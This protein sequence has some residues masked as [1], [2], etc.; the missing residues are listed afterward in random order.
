MIKNIQLYGERCSGTNY[1]QSLIEM[2]F[3]EIPV[4]WQ[5]GWKHWFP[6]LKNTKETLF[7]VIIRDPLDWLSS[8]NRTPFHTELKKLSFSEFIRREWYSVY[9]SDSGFKEDH[10]LIGKE[11]IIDRDPE[12]GK[13]FEN[14]I[15]LRNSK[16]KH[17][18]GIENKVEN[19][20]FVRYEDISGD[21]SIIKDVA[22]KFNISL[23]FPE[24]RRTEY[25]KGNKTF[26]VYKKKEY[27]K[28]SE[29]DRQFILSQL[30]IEQENK[31]GYLK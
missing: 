10:P 17:F 9:D 30:D 26:G 11:M 27:Q 25:F 22:A 2:N 5:H 8:I 20:A 1:L 24:I 6:K 15:K 7:I 31:I 14:V 21:E 28:I 4:T 18:L 13:R 3:K 16:N 12:T 29:E 19:F 23:R